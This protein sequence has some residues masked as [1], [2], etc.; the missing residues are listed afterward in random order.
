MSKCIAHMIFGLW[1]PLWASFGCLVRVQSRPEMCFLDYG[2]IP[3]QSPPYS[4]GKS[5]GVSPLQQ[6]T[7]V[8]YRLFTVKDHFGVFQKIDFSFSS[9]RGK[10]KCHKGRYSKAEIYRRGESLRLMSHSLLASRGE[11]ADIDIYDR[12]L[13]IM[14]QIAVQTLRSY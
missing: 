3:R 7:C 8:L 13:T 12:A 9:H 1:G 6:P 4:G 5:S 10:P 2:G 14:T 11:P